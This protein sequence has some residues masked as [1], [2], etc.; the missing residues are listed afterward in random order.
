MREPQSVHGT[1]D[2]LSMEHV[3]PMF[4]VACKVKY[5][6]INR[7]YSQLT[8]YSQHS[9]NTQNNVTLGQHLSTL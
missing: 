1:T 5:L 8:T 9:D 3:R 7:S 4:H 2:V 6:P